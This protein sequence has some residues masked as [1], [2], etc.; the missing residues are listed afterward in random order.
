M[1]FEEILD[2]LRKVNEELEDESIPLERAMQ[3]YEDGVKLSKMADQ[4][5]SKAETRIKQ[6]GKDE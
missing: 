3:L 2:K 5:L 6:L 4:I 1:K